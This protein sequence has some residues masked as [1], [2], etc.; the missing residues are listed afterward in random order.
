MSICITKLAYRGY[1]IR[2]IA[3][4]LNKLGV[5][6]LEGNYTVIICV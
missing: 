4:F 3:T 2:Q 1:I 6:I 5:I